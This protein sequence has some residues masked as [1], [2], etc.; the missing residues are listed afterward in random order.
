MIRRPVAGTYFRLL[1]PRWAHQPTSGAGAARHGGRMN[2]PGTEALYLAADIETAAAEFKQASPVLPPGMLVSY[3]VMLDD[4]ADFSRGF[5]P[6]HWPSIWEDLPCD[7]R[8]LVLES[9][10]PPSWVIAD[11]VL[12]AGC[13]GVLFPS[14]VKPGGANLVVYPLRLTDLNT[15][16]AMD[17]HGDLPR[18]QA[19]WLPS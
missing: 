11:L 18:D 10:E 19:S 7:W 15:V 8:K 2:R 14:S 3:H 4:V 13:Q 5:E 9:I 1:T 16:A 6:A 12:A 17:P